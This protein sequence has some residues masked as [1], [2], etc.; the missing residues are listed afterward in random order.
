MS[1]ERARALGIEPCPM[2]GSGDVRWRK[3][4]WTDVARTWMLFALEFPFRL[5][6]RTSRPTYTPVADSHIP[7]PTAMRP[8]DAELAAADLKSRTYWRHRDNYEDTI[9]LATAAR[10]WKCSA[11]GGKGSD[12]R[13]LDNVLASRRRMVDLEDA[14]PEE[15]AHGQ[16]PLDRDGL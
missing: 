1:I 12:F 15:F 10:F 6:S 2:C 11:C 8:R 7:N 4:R 13:E 3:R 16:P 9:G 14:L 5:L